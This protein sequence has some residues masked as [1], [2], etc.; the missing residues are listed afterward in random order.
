MLCHISRTAE[1]TKVCCSKHFKNCQKSSSRKAKRINCDCLSTKSSVFWRPRKGRILA[2]VPLYLVFFLVTILILDLLIFRIFHLQEHKSK[3][4]RISAQIVLPTML[5][6]DIFD[7]GS[8]REVTGN[9][10]RSDLQ[11]TFPHN[12][13]KIAESINPVTTKWESL[14]NQPKLSEHLLTSVQMSTHKHVPFQS[15]PN[16]A[17]TF[18]P[19]R[20]GNSKD[21]PALLHYLRAVTNSIPPADSCVYWPLAVPPAPVQITPILP[22]QLRSPTYLRLL[23]QAQTSLIPA[24]GWS[25]GSCGPAASGVSKTRLPPLLLSAWMPPYGSSYPVAAA[26]IAAAGAVQPPPFARW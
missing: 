20:T 24:S 3:R 26:P 5:S 2:L 23:A 7:Q 21:L 8:Q 6:S 13:T 4:I 18:A 12:W 17:C 9:N 19:A 11:E 1:S 14:S 25:P 15:L 10:L 16:H 22:S